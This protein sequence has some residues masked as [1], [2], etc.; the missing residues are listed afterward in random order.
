MTR[1]GL[2]KGLGALI[3]ASNDEGLVN[4]LRINDV[5]PNLNQPRKSFDEEKIKALAES[6][7]QQEHI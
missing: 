1:K 7:K 2:G 6:I 4:E 5:E 3:E